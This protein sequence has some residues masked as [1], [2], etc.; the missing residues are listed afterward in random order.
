MYNTW[1]QLTDLLCV[2]FVLSDVKPGNARVKECLEDKRNDPEFSAECK[3]TFE[4]MMA[5]RAT[6][7]RLDAK[8]RDLCKVSSLFPRH[9]PFAYYLNPLFFP[10]RLTS[11][12][13]A[14]MK[15]TA[16]IVSLGMTA[17]SWNASR[18]TRMSW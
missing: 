5:R 4:D 11:K 13:S 7:F 14:V 18:I 3:K 17:V 9:V 6:D 10:H 8:L 1:L 16:S 2:D 15:R 12:K